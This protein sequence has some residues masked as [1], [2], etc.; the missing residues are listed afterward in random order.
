MWPGLVRPG[1]FWSVWIGVF[2]PAG[3]RESGISGI[4]RENS[5]YHF[6]GSYVTYEVPI[7]K[8]IEER[9]L[10]KTEEVQEV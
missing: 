6:D 5:W 4:W 9:N 10:G 8:E 1:L 7:C 2:I 3:C